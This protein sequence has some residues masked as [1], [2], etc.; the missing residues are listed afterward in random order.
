MKGEPAMSIKI[1][2]GNLSLKVSDTDLH[3]LFTE[4]GTV[5]SVSIV[6]TSDIELTPA[7]LRILGLNT[8]KKLGVV[9]MASRSQARTA[10]KLFHG[11]ELFGRSLVVKLAGPRGV[12][13]RP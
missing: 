12:G 7:R 11:K 6:K 1:Y 3:E 2:V 10:A 8:S 13:D 4:A 9:H 5:K